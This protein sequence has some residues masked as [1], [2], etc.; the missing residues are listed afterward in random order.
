MYVDILENA[1]LNMIVFK[2][3]SIQTDDIFKSDV[4]QIGYTP[5]GEDCSVKTDIRNIREDNNS[6]LADKITAC[7]SGE[8]TTCEDLGEIEGEQSETVELIAWE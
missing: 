1:P 5:T 4:F 3:R 8:N 7:E 2:L 6:I